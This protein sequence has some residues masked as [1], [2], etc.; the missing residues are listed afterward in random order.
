MLINSWDIL[1]NKNLDNDQLMYML[2]NFK[3]APSFEEKGPGF[4]S[5]GI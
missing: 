4:A 3:M 2:D 1:D 5:S